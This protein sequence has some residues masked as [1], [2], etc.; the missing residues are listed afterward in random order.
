[1]GF[2]L[3]TVLRA[4][5]SENL[6]GLL[7]YK[8]PS[9]SWKPCRLAVGWLSTRFLVSIL[10]AQKIRKIHAYTGHPNATGNVLC[11]PGIL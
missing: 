9:P 1:M 5:L 3:K 6:G 11:K 7:V 2:K 8:E 10:T 4:D